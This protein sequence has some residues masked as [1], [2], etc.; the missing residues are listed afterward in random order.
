[1]SNETETKQDW[2]KE[3][4]NLNGDDALILLNAL[5]DSVRYHTAQG[6]KQHDFAER[7][8]GQRNGEPERMFREAATE[9]AK[10][11]TLDSVL[12]TFRIK[13]RIRMTNE[14]GA[15]DFVLSVMNREER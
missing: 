5:A 6:V 7:I 3:F 8:S 1:M 13:R 15:V 12:E 9:R 10:V 14:S 2:T 4:P 11:E